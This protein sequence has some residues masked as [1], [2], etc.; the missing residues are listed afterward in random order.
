MSF[1]NQL[2]MQASALQNEQAAQLQ[3]LEENADKTERACK[4]VWHYLQ[5]LARQLTVLSPEA[6]RFSLDGKAYWPPMKLI[7]F[8]ADARKK[9]LRDKEV[10]DF[11]AIGWEIVPRVG[12]PISASVSVNFPP[13][14]ERVQKRLAFGHVEHE[15]KDVRHP[16]KNTLQAIRFDYVTQARGNVTVTADHDNAQLVFRL[17]NADGFGVVSTTW[18]AER[19][20]NEWMDE[21][22]KLIVA[23]PSRFA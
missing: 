15:R 5:E 3:N 23:Q 9:S 22:A 20:N 19:L 8:R 16:E 13:E 17:A 6:P 14:L 1:L 2:R 11:I 4:I 10:Y 21:L 12:A 18:Q 7:N